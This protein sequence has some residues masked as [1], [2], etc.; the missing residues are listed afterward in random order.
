MPCLGKLV[1]NNFAAYDWLQESTFK[2][3][4]KAELA[5]LFAANG[6]SQVAVYP[7]A[8]G[9]AAAHICTK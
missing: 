6:F 7:F 4:S 9:V 2:F 1:T 3:L 8:G 5:E